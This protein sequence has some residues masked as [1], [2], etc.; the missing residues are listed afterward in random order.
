MLRRS[1]GP[2]S[3]EISPPHQTSGAGAPSSP[4]HE[5]ALADCGSRGS[6]LRGASR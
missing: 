3:A 4:P 5:Y 1:A 6:R 2:A